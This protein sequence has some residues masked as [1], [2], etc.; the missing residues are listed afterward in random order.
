MSSRP[1]HVGRAYTGLGLF[2]TRI[3]K[4]NGYIATY[5]GPILD[6]EEAEK[7]ER[8]GAKYMFELTK[9]LTIDGSPRWNVARYMNHSCWPNAKPMIDTRDKK[10]TFVALR[11]IL[12]GEEITYNYGKEY[13]EYFLAIGGCLCAG[14]RI[15]AAARREKKATP[16][17]AGLS[18][19][20]NGKLNGARHTKDAASGRPQARKVGKGG[21]NAS[22]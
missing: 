10:I 20:A 5:R 3:I 19:R 11:D 7:R 16:A 22:I 4:R 17:H 8:Q 14:C 9:K 15:R 1:F 2:A 13:Y 12:P 6:V 18:R 21:R